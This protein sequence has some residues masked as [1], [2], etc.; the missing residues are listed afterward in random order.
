MVA[1]LRVL[2]DVARGVGSDPHRVDVDVEGLHRLIR[3]TD[4][5]L[6]WLLVGG[7]VTHLILVAVTLSCLFDGWCP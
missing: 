3:W 4:T 7:I 2:G 6:F 1:C 5:A